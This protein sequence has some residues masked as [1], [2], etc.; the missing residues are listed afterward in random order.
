MEAGPTTN[1]YFNIG[2][3]DLLVSRFASNKQ[4]QINDSEVRR[5][6]PRAWANFCS[7]KGSF[8]NNEIYQSGKDSNLFCMKIL[9]P[10]GEKEVH[11]TLI[12]AEDQQI[13]SQAIAFFVL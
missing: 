4:T 7:T 8:S 5:V 10:L 11:F 6:F 12:E 3:E 2:G 9:T 1:V 13:G